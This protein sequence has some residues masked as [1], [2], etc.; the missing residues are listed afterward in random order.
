MCSALNP[1]L[2]D[3]ALSEG[4]GADLVVLVPDQTAGAG[5]NEGLTGV[6]ALDE[7]GG[8]RVGEVVVL[9]SQLLHC[10]R[11][12]ELLGKNRERNTGRNY[13]ITLKCI[14]LCCCCCCCFVFV[15]CFCVSFLAG[16]V[17]TC[18]SFIRSGQNHL[19][20]HSER[21]KKTRQTEEEVGRQH[22][23]MDRPGFRQV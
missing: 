5:N 20:T 6:V 22:Q 9:R 7:T 4:G 23:E 11:V 14:S 8:V 17:W 3:D 2:T 12:G 18:L 15:F 16:V 21:G 10:A 1:N 19:A 13:K